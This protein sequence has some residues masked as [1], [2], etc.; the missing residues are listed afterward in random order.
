MSKAISDEVLAAIRLRT[1]AG[2]AFTSREEAFIADLDCEA[3]LAE[4]DRLRHLDKLAREWLAAEEAWLNSDM[5]TKDDIEKSEAS[6]AARIAY[7]AAAEE[8]HER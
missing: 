8:K 6:G 3:L 2:I 4:V 1:A 5:G 7:R